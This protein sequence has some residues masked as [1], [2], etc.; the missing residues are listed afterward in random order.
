[1]AH[2]VGGGSGNKG[3]TGVVCL[4]CALQQPKEG[5][6]AGL[7][8]MGVWLYDEGGFQ[9]ARQAR[10]RHFLCSNPGMRAG[11]SDY[12]DEQAPKPATQASRMATRG[13]SQPTTANPSQSRRLLRSPLRRVWLLLNL[14]HKL[15]PGRFRSWKYPVREA[16]CAGNDPDSNLQTLPEP[17]CCLGL[18][19]E[20]YTRR[21]QLVFSTAHDPTSQSP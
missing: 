17:L 14:N 6:I 9:M 12:A 5:P 3:C 8:L 10:F 2:G 13:Q 19:H 7:E 20:Q 11:G 21:P 1:M 15:D 4:V 18:I 16:D